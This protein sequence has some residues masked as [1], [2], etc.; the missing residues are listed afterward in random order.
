LTR[1]EVARLHDATRAVLAAAIE[2]CGTTFSDFQDAHGLTG[3]YQRFLAVYEREGEACPRCGGLVKRRTQ[4]QRS[5]Y[6]CG[7]CV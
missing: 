5:T 1:A 6:W 7:G 2:A 3:S 4:A